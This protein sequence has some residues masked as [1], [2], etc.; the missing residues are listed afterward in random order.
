ME[1]SAGGRTARSPGATPSSTTTTTA[2]PATTPAPAST[3]SSACFQRTACSDSWQLIAGA[4][5]THWSS[6]VRA[7]PVVGDGTQ[8]NASVGLL[9]TFKPE[10]PNEWDRRPLIAR[11][12]YGQSTDCDLAPIVE[13]RCFNVNQQDDTSIVLFDVGQVLVQRINGWPLDLAGFIGFLKHEDRGLQP[14]SWQINAYYKLYYYF[15]PWWRDTLRTRFG[16]G[17]GISYASRVPF[18]EQR[19]QDTRGRDTSQAAALSRPH[20]RHQHRRPVQGAR[21]ARDLRRHRRLAPLGHLRLGAPVQQRER[22]LEL[23]L[24]LCRDRL[25]ACSSSCSPRCGSARS[26]CARCTSPTRAATPRSRA[27]WWPAATGSRRA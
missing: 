23:H 9:Y 13:W 4:G 10:Q 17:G 27:R 15:G 18:S 25:L 7:S 2:F 3:S 1:D 8:F 22:R 5:L 6:G 14:D 11:F 24:W 21:A 16:L 20:H 12:G 19:D 26:A